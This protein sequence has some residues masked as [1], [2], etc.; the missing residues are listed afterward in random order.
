MASEAGS[1]DLDRQAKPKPPGKAG[2]P[3][4][5]LTNAFRAKW[6]LSQL[7]IF[8]VEFEPPVDRT[9]L[10]RR[11]TALKPFRAQVN[12]SRVCNAGG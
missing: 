6:H 8:V 4:S 11:E 7:V 3:I 1:A 10:I 9:D 12:S 2:R 5:L